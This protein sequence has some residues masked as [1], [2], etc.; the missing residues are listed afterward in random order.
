MTSKEKE[1][2]MGNLWLASHARKTNQTYRNTEGS[3]GNSC[4]WMQRVVP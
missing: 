4:S 2:N 1:L 3:L